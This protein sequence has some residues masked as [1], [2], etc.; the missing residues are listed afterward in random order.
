MRE[1]HCSFCFVESYILNVIKQIFWQ[2][3]Q[4]FLWYRES[5]IPEVEKEIKDA[6]PSGDE[7]ETEK[8]T[9]GDAAENGDADE[10]EEDEE[11]DKEKK[12]EKDSTGNCS[13]T[14]EMCSET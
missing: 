2:H 8:S 6:E 11:E 9:N 10:K 4:C 14:L 12:D 1:S 5:T 13:Q 3:I 7:E